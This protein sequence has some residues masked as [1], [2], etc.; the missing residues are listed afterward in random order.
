MAVK[1]P[2]PKPVI[3]TTIWEDAWKS[4]AIPENRFAAAAA[5]N[6]HSRMPNPIRLAGSKHQLQV[7]KHFNEQ[8]HP[9]SVPRTRFGNQ[10]RGQRWKKNHHRNGVSKG[11]GCYMRGEPQSCARASRAA[12]GIS[13]L[14]RSAGVPPAVVGKCRGH[15]PA[16]GS[17]DNRNQRRACDNQH[18]EAIE[19]RPDGQPHGDAKATS[20]QCGRQHQPTASSQ[21][22]IGNRRPE[23][24]PDCGASANALMPAMRSTLMPAFRSKYGM[25]VLMN[26]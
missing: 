10:D 5:P 20:A 24:I 12:A 19:L 1:T 11:G 18:D 2:P 14:I 4:T 3:Q 13:G 6:G 7:A 22:D 15:K 16:I 21:T 9:G 26:P 17:S 23:K 25:E 8:L